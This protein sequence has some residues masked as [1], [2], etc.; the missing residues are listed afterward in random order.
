MTTRPAHRRG[1]HGLFV[2]ALLVVLAPLVPVHQAVAPV[3]AAVPAPVAPEPITAPTLDMQPALPPDQ[4]TAPR[5]FSAYDNAKILSYNAN[6]PSSAGAQNEYNYMDPQSIQVAKYTPNV[7]WP[8]TAQNLGGYLYARPA[9]AKLNRDEMTAFHLGGSG[10]LYANNWNVPG[11]YWS[12]TYTSL[13]AT[14]HFGNP[15]A[16]SR[17]E[18]HVAVVSRRSTSQMWVRERDRGTWGN[19]THLTGTLTGD[20][21]IVSRDRTRMTVFARGN[22][23]RL[24]YKEYSEADG[25][26]TS[27][28]KQ[29][30]G[31]LVKAEAPAVIAR[32]E[33]I[34]EVFARGLDNKLYNRTW[35]EGVGWSGWLLLGSDFVA[36]PSA[37]ARYQGHMAVFSRRANGAV[38]WRQWTEEN[39][40]YPWALLGGNAIES[41]AAF[42]TSSDDIAF[43]MRGSDRVYRFRSWNQNTKTWSAWLKLAGSWA[44]APAVA[45]A[46]PGQYRV[47]GVQSGSNALGALST[48]A[49]QLARSSNLAAPSGA[50]AQIRMQ[51]SA[52]LVTAGTMTFLATAGLQPVTGGWQWYRQLY[53]IEA[54]GKY[55]FVNAAQILPGVVQD[56]DQ[57]G[58]IYLTSADLD[59]DGGR[60]LV[61]ALYNE[62]HS[63]T[64]VTIVV[65]K[66]NTAGSSTRFVKTYTGLSTTPQNI[67]VGVGAFDADRI[68]N[69][70]VLAVQTLSEYRLVGYSFR[71]KQIIALAGFDKAYDQPNA[72]SVALDLAIGDV[73]TSTPGDEVVV[74]WSTVDEDN[75]SNDVDV[76]DGL[77]VWSKPAGGTGASWDQTTDTNSYTYQSNF[78]EESRS[79]YDIAVA[80]G[81]LDGSAPP[82][83]ALARKSVQNGT[84]GLLTYSG[85]EDL[86]FRARRASD[87]L[88]GSGGA[89]ALSIAARD[90]D[91]DGRAEIVLGSTHTQNNGVMGS[92]VDTFTERQG[93]PDHYYTVRQSG[94]AE[95][96]YRTAYYPAIV[97][98]DVDN[99]SYRATL[100]GCDTFSDVRVVAVVHEPPRWEL[101]KD[102]TKTTVAEA[103]IGFGTSQTATTGAEDGVTVMAG[104]S[105]TVGTS[106]ETPVVPVVEWEVEV[107][108]SFEYNGKFSTATESSVSETSGYDL[109]NDPIGEGDPLEH[110]MV[111]YDETSYDCF[112]YNIFPRNEPTK[113]TRA[114]YCEPGISRQD[115]VSLRD[116][117]SDLRIRAGN[118]WSNVGRRTSDPTSYPRTRVLPAGARLLWSSNV[119][120]EA[121]GSTNGGV[122]KTW[123][124][125]IEESETQIEEHSIEA[126]L[127]VSAAVT[128]AGVKVGASATAGA[129]K[130]WTRSVGTTSG[131]YLEG[132]LEDWRNADCPRISGKAQCTSYRYRPYLYQV[133]TR[134]LLGEVYDYMVLDY[135]VPYIQT[136]TRSRPESSGVI[137]Q[138]LST[139]AQDAPS[140][141]SPATPPAAPVIGSPTHPEPQAWSNN[142]TVTFTWGQPAGDTAALEGYRFQL[143]QTP[144]TVPPEL[145]TVSTS[146]HTFANLPDGVYYI[147][148]R[149]LGKDGTWSETAHREVRIDTQ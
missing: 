38:L 99:T 135:Y 43:V 108:A 30:G 13:E 11:G 97:V 91:R 46:Q 115:A 67:A 50:P 70:I 47:L 36:A 1:R 54:N 100:V 51:R 102:G 52:A 85:D 32:S 120:K 116:W 142:S 44:S 106:G 119:D 90:T 31:L 9:V 121:K 110:G 75:F 137:E 92:F 101:I 132:R 63:Q 148:V 57:R 45:S 83:I 29:L 131:L 42:S 28:W 123:S 76:R 93:G 18:N 79:A 103:S 65:E 138:D 122:G 139:E 66:F 144:D 59:N 105:L 112:W 88:S 62:S 145:G 26:W 86:D 7:V 109:D 125:A 114:M 20:P 111:V 39:K 41:P 146:T 128:A 134:S 87:T 71:N 124:M 25:G 8:F 81:E 147:H 12:S 107:T 129:G 77:G 96:L 23:N 56:T 4:C 15:A 61:T 113:R 104:A 141:I 5:A 69:D 24:W 84:I 6:H 78:G 73:R 95:D 16:V 49:T 48:T 40:W 149:A 126:S 34:I 58:K 94:F 35:T 53:K 3:A 80:V 136:D 127:T 60:E 143:D 68:Q 133:Q 82:E 14:G 130:T 21:A 72:D 118:S 55:S 117:R 22:N 89:T 98:G 10:I 19:W 37:V 27:G 17:D 33:Q 2:L 140:V 64:G 74:A